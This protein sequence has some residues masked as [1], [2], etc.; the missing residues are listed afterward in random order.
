MAK[1]TFVRV[2]L[3]LIGAKIWSLNN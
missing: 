1:L 3:V 2:L